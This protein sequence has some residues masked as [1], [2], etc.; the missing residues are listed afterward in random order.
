M[1]EIFGWNALLK[2]N[3]PEITDLLQ[4]WPTLEI[5]GWKALESILKAHQETPFCTKQNLYYHTRHLEVMN[6]TE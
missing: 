2:T 5:F 6:N 4:Y 3:I 1:L